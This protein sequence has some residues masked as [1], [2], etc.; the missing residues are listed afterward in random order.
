MTKVRADG[1]DLEFDFQGCKDENVIRLDDQPELDGGPHCDFAVFPPTRPDFI[2]EVK[3]PCQPSAHHERQVQ[4][5]RDMKV[6]EE[7]PLETKLFRAAAVTFS[8]VQDNWPGKAGLL[9]IAVFGLECLD[10]QAVLSKA[11]LGP[12]QTSLLRRLKQH[13]AMKGMVA[14]ALLVTVAGWCAA[15]P[16]YPLRRVSVGAAP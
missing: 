3:D 4:F 7:K 1:D 8:Y 14:K 2:L 13:D 15:F 5:L 12:M 9:Y 10:N 16:H 11:I 6:S